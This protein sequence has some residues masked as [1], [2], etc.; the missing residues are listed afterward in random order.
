M[1]PTRDRSLS[2]TS[3]AA[4]AD[5]PVIGF[6]CV[7]ERLRREILGLRA[8]GSEF[9]HAFDS[10]PVIRGAMLRVQAEQECR[11]ARGSDN[12]GVSEAGLNSKGSKSHLSNLP[13]APL[14]REPSRCQSSFSTRFTECFSMSQGV[15]P[16]LQ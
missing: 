3:N 10:L 7:S 2:A 16:R 5:Q 15:S 4:L 9:E 12:D 8:G 1:A 14:T 6:K 13:D 11:C